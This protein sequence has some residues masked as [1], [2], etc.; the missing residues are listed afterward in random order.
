MSEISTKHF[1]EVREGLSRSIETLTDLVQRDSANRFFPNGINKIIF[2]A[3]FGGAELTLDV[4][5]PAPS[6]VLS[7]TALL[8]TKN[9][10]ISFRP[11][12]EGTL[13]YGGKTV[14]C[15]GCTQV[16]YA[17]DLTVKGALDV[18]KFRTKYSNEYKV[19]MNFAILI[20]G[21]RGIYIHEG[22]DTLAGNGGESAG[23]IHVGPGNAEA[24]WNWVDGPTRIQI[25]YPW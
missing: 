6:H 25:N 3:K 5:G 13:S 16:S 7:E 19:D 2:T 4:E 15:L 22:A 14:P 11:N 18:D 24:F 21:L 12:G 9:A 17:K 23:C 1:E 20:M 10:S 8:A